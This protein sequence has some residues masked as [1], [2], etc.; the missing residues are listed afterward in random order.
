MS[1]PRNAQGDPAGHCE[2]RLIPENPLS[3]RGD[4]EGRTAVQPE[5]THGRHLPNQAL[6]GAE[7]PANK[8]VALVQR[9]DAILLMFQQEV[10]GRPYWLQQPRTDASRKHTLGVQN[11]GTEGFA[12]RAEVLIPRD[13]LAPV[14][15]ERLEIGRASCRERVWVRVVSVGY[16]KNK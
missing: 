10:R 9:H 16:K 6:G 14:D 13:P 3:F 8:P 2:G 12:E 4:V 11:A 7:N 5:L 1:Q 15:V